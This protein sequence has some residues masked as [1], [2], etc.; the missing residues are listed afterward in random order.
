MRLLRL[1][2][3]A[4]ITLPLGPDLGEETP[5]EPLSMA[6]CPACEQGNGPEAR[7]CSACGTPLVMRCPACNAINARSRPACHHCHAAL[8]DLLAP[9]VLPGPE[10]TGPVVPLLTHPGEEPVPDD[11]HLELLPEM[12]AP[13]SAPL[14]HGTPSASPLVGDPD[15]PRHP[16]PQ[17]EHE[18][19]L[20]E[21]RARRRAAV[22]RSQLRRQAMPPAPVVR[23]VLV[24]EA[25]TVSRAQV[26]AVLEAFGFRP[27]VAVSVAEAEGLSQRCPHVAAFLG[28]GDDVQSAAELCQRLR[29]APRWRPSALFAIGE[30]ERHTDRVR[31]QLA[32][33][34]E[35]L[36]RP[37]RRGDVARALQA[38][39]LGL[40]QDPRHGAAPAP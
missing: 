16:A 9:A 25:D 22:R 33:A 37:V 38:C 36:F 4:C 2:A 12:L 31:L 30:R 35:V 5:L 27:H 24:M 21:A 34:D 7:Y 20:A 15:A 23:D 39:G 18:P 3:F 14:P 26:C 40:P 13:V 17:A 6:A 32:G 8:T 10:S 1:D 28:L 29:D 19:D 11:W